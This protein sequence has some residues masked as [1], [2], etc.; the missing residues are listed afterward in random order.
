MVTLPLSSWHSLCG[1][2]PTGLRSCEVKVCVKRSIAACPYGFWGG[3]IV[4]AS[5]TVAI[6]VRSGGSQFVGV[7]D[8]LARQ[9]VE[10]ELLVCDSGS[11]DGSAALARAHGARVLEIAPAEF[12]PRRD[13]QPADERSTRRA[14][15]AAEPGRRAGG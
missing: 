13:P 12:S 3:G 2:K 10:H 9:S 6:P 4:A 14:R 11:R 15:G 8:A 5:V 7:L 1:G